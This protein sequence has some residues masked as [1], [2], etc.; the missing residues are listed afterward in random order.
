MTV[1]K[2]RTL[3]KSALGATAIAAGTGIGITLFTPNNDQANSLVLSASSNADGQ[4]F[5]SGWSSSAKQLFLFPVPMRAHDCCCSADGRVAVFFSRRPGTQLYIVDLINNRLL[6]SVQCPAGYHFYG[7]GVFSADSRYL[8]TTENHYLAPNP[9]HSGVIA[10]YDV[11]DIGRSGVKRLAR[12]Y[13]G[14]IGPHQLAFLGDQRT[15]AVA[16]GGILTHPNSQRQKLNVETMAPSLTY[17]DSQNGTVI[18]QYAPQHHQMSIRH[19]AVSANDQVILGVQHQ[20][21]STDQVPL[22]LSH[23]GQQ[24]LQAMQAQHAI[25]HKQQQYIASIAVSDDARFAISTS[26][27]GASIALWNLSTLRCIDTMTLRDVAGATYL[28]DQQRF[29]VSNGLGQLVALTANEQTLTPQTLS[30]NRQIR[31]DNHLSRLT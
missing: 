26:P 11:S 3:I 1:I 25:W 9:K 12:F 28:A 7:H 17:L 30:V 19:L 22:V 4:H 27:R 13:S 5:I 24:Q 2:R 21:Q 14:G 8:F 31:W 23:Q 6:P 18:D 10:V 29:V 15:L 16:N 20:G